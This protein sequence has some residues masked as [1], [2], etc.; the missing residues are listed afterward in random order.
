MF[1]IWGIVVGILSLLVGIFL[2]F[3]FPSSF[4]TQE[5]EL[6]IGGIFLGV[7]ALIVGGVLIFL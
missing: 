3:F 4:K 1:G 7:I 2:V 5:T 6:A